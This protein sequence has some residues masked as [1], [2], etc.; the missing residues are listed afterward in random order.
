MMRP[1]GKISMSHPDPQLA[2]WMAYAAASAVSTVLFLAAGMSGLRWVNRAATRVGVVSLLATVLCTVASLSAAM[3]RESTTEAQPEA[4]E[5]CKRVSCSL[6]NTA[7]E[8]GRRPEQHPGRRK[9]AGALT[10][11]RSPETH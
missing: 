7:P 6:E 2:R 5:W 1:R 9:S 11:A 8:A 3:Q 10:Q 4:I